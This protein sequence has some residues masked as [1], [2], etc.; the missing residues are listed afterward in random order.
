MSS[1]ENYTYLED[2]A[3]QGQ[4]T[5]HLRAGDIAL[6]LDV[7]RLAIFHRNPVSQ[8]IHAAIFTRDPFFLNVHRSTAARSIAKVFQGTGGELR[9]QT[10]G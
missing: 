6:S 9:V 3:S 4:V 7:R 10:G 2:I 1:K 8:M 5:S